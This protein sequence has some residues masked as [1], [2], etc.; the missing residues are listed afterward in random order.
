MAAQEMGDVG[1]AVLE[2]ATKGRTPAAQRFVYIDGNIA[3]KQETDDV[4]M[5]VGCRQGQ[6]AS[7]LGPLCKQGPQ[8]LQSTRL[9][10]H[11]CWRQPAGILGLDIGFEEQQ[12]TYD[13]DVSVATSQM[14]GRM[15]GLVWAKVDVSVDQ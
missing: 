10:S 5:A 4:E 9:H 12:A 13:V 1:M 11:L 6:Q 3:E 14:Q 2:G 8:H 15:P 7:R